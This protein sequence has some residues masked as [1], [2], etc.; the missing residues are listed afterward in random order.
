[1]DPAFASQIPA[2][3]W[4]LLFAAFVGMLG[5]FWHLLLS[6]IRRELSRLDEL[7]AAVRQV[8]ERVTHLDKR[9]TVVETK[10]HV[11][12]DIIAALEE[13]DRRRVL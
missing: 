10:V 9:V 3:F 12:D 11:R 8:D 13:R 1:M 5:L 2:W 7:P 4:A 6:V